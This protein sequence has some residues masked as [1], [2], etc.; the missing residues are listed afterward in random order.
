MASTTTHRMYQPALSELPKDPKD[1]SALLRSYIPQVANPITSQLSFGVKK[2]PNLVQSLS[3][4]ELKVRQASLVSLSELFHSPQNVSQ[5]L[6]TRVV[7]HLVNFFRSEN[8][9]CRQKSTECLYL[10][11][12]LAIGRNAILERKDTFQE[13]V[14]AINDKDDQTRKH[15][16]DSFR[17][18]TEQDLGVEFAY[19]CHLFY[20]ICLNLAKERLDI[21]IPMLDTAYN[22][23]RRVV[24]PSI[25]I[26]SNALALF[27]SC[28]NESDIWQVQV[29]AC[30]CIMMLC[31]FEECKKTAVA[32]GTIP[33]LVNLLSDRNS[34][35][36]AAAAGALMTITIHNEGKRAMVRSDGLK[37]LTKLFD[38]H[39]DLAKLNAIK[40][41]TNCADDFRGK[42]FLINCLDKLKSIIQNS[43]DKHVVDAA[44][45]AV[46]V[47]TARP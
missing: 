47:V 30:Q 23:L 41:A 25:A 24:N 31:F 9:T 34:S 19:E 20:G 1:A 35:L 12:N 42:Y 33:V 8:I 13:M 46:K 15:I 44:S 17:N 22:C 18:V 2:V 21:Q 7:D 39:D 32:S 10:I 36:R 29:P 28:A 40:A 14:H 6:A 27:T 45:T 37:S 16:Y 4:D 38:D 26:E 43:S 3:S 11:S 5:G